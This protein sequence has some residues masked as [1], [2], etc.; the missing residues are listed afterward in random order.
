MD[1]I[2]GW[3]QPAKEAYQSVGFVFTWP[4]SIVSAHL[5]VLSLLHPGTLLAALFEIGP[6][7][8]VLPLM[9]IWAVK[10]C[11]AGRWFE[12][13]LIFGFSL[14]VG[15]IL[16]N[17]QGSTGVRNTSRLYSFLFLTVIYFVP[18]VWNWAAHRANGWRYTAA[19]LYLI[20]SAVD[21][22]CSP[23]RY[24]PSNRP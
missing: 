15:S 19:G 16:L 8:L 3:L 14:T 4:P 24:R 22:F 12:S 21:S 9:L 5:G 23:H 11:R 10:A 20:S 1:I 2:R 6:V 13:A 17:F 18:L 7:L